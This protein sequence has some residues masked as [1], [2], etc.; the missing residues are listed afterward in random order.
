[1]SQDHDTN[2]AR[3]QAPRVLPNMD[4]FR[5]ASFLSLGV[6]HS[7]VE[8]LREVLTKCVRRG[9]LDTPAG[10]RNEA[11]DSGGVVGTG[12]LLVHGLGALD[13]RHGEKLL[14]HIRVP[15]QDLQDL[16]ASILLCEMCRMTFL[17]EEFSRPNERHWV[18]ELP[19]HHV[20]PLV[21]LQREV[22]VRLD[23][24]GKVRVHGRLAG[25]TDGDGPLEVR[26]ATLGHPRN[27]GG[28][29]LN[30]VLLSLQIVGADEDGEVGIANFE[31]LDFGVKPKLD[32]L[33]DGIARRFEDVAA[34]D[35]DARV[36]ARALDC[37]KDGNPHRSM[38]SF[39]PW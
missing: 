5:L 4:V 9:R 1:M 30:V 2:G 17:P 24:A 22:A 37:G 26:F 6:L 33:P 15:V 39:G 11:F 29:A 21:E 31:R 34:G 25:G 8:H 10:G 3:C 32:V 35:L 23:L 38:R 20:V 36:S 27:L 19:P 7:N 18:L 16:F 28:E 12:E 14:I 13:D